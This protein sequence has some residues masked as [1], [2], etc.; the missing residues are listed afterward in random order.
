MLRV[1]SEL[2]LLQAT[3]DPQLAKQYF[4]RSLNQARAPGALSWELRTAMS[5]ARLEIRLDSHDKAQKTLSHAYAH[6]RDRF[7]TTDLKDA[8]QILR[9]LNDMVLQSIKHVNFVDTAFIVLKL[10]IISSVAIEPSPGR[11][12]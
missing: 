2:L 10:E 12:E 8:R 3:P 6:F 4:L 1:K 11:R 5:I 7:Q 9:E